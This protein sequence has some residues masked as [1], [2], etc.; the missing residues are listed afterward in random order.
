MKK[1]IYL[2]L[3]LVI[4]NHSLFSANESIDYIINNYIKKGDWQN[5]KIEL[6]NY[7]IINQKDP[8][9]FSFLS[10]V[11][12]EL[13]QYDEAIINC[14]KAIINEA[15]MEK[16]G[17]LYFNLGSY[18]YNRGTK[19]VAL[20]MFQKSI[21]L[22]N[23]IANPYYMIGLIYYED[24]DLDNCIIYWQ[25]YVDISVESDKREQVALVIE[26]WKKT[27]EESIKELGSDTNA[28]ITNE[29]YDNSKEEDNNSQ[30]SI[31]DSIENE[32]KNSKE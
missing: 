6:S 21:E 9:G 11:C 12:N 20:T 22:N 24:N 8:D 18:Y 31:Q 3:S 27:K 15:S 1:C 28:D 29:K 30:K 13:R 32:I 26:Q 14:R 2:F 17:E 16:K 23:L 5:A 10:V 4:L 7:V 25:K 19:N